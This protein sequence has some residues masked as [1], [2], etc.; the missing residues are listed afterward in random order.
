MQR[1]T[2]RILDPHVPLITK[3]AISAL[4]PRLKSAKAQMEALTVSVRLHYIGY[5]TSAK[6]IADHLI[7]SGFRYHIYS[8]HKSMGYLGELLFYY[9]CAVLD[10]FDIPIEEES[11]CYLDK[12]AT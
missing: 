8:R 5:V 7:S 1:V 10:T 9:H 6:Y 11:C 3:A 2:K 4:N 12:N